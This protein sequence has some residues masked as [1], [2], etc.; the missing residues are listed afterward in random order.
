[1]V[2]GKAVPMRILVVVMSLFLPSLAN[3]SLDVA[4][5]DA[6]ITVESSRYAVTVDRRSG[7]ITRLGQR[8][9]QQVDR[10]DDYGF[11]KDGRSKITIEKTD[12]GR[13]TV[14]I[15]GAFVRKGRKTPSDL[16][17]V[18]RYVFHDRSSV[19]GCFVTVRQHNIQTHSDVYMTPSW[20][21]L[22]LLDFSDVAAERKAFSRQIAAKRFFF[23][24]GAADL[25]QLFAV[26]DK[27]RAKFAELTRPKIPIARTLLDDPLTDKTN[28]IDISGAW[29]ANRGKMTERSPATNNAFTVAAVPPVRDCLLETS[30][31]NNDGSDHVYLCGR[32]Q[33]ARNH[34]SMSYLNFPAHAVRIDRVVNGRRTVL[35]EVNGVPD[36]RVKPDTH[37]AFE[38]RGSRLRAFRNNELLVEAVDST[39][40]S[41]RV[42]LGV[43]GEYPTTFS[44]VR[45][46]EVQPLQSAIAAIRIEQPPTRHAYFR[47]ETNA[48]SPLLITSN[49]DVE[50]P[51]VVIAIENQTHLRD[52]PVHEQRIELGSLKAGE[53]R[54][55]ECPL[56][57]ALWRSGDYTVSAVVTSPTRK[58]GTESNIAP[59]LA[60]RASDQRVLARARF[61]IYLRKRPN[62]ERMIV[63]AW[64][65]G[66][67]KLLAEHGF[68]RFKVH[69]A[70]TIS[71]WRDGKHYVIDNP[72]RLQ[73]ATAAPRLQYLHD[74]FDECVRYG[75]QGYL[76]LEYTR[77]LAEGVEAAYALK[78]NGTELQTRA[79]DF[80]ELG[81][82]R[83]NPFHPDNIAT[84]TNFW[85]T[86]LQAF[87]DMPGWQ[88]TLLNSESERTLDVYGNDYWL[89][90]ARKEL[91][92]DVPRD[93]ADPWG[94]KPKDRPLPADGIVETNDPYYRFYRWWW[95]RGEGQGMLHAK[96]AEVV[97][98]I[99]PDMRVWHDPALRQPFVRG[100]LRGLD[101]IWQW[102][103][104]WPM[105][106]R[107]PLVADE[108]KLAAVDNQVTVLQL[109]LIAWG[110][111][112][113]PRDAPRWPYVKRDFYLA[114]HSPAVMRQ[115]VWLALSRG[116]G[117]IS[118]H[119]LE[120]VH[121]T[122]LKPGDDLRE[123]RGIGHRAYMY[124]SPDTLAA[125]S[126]MNRRVLAPYGMVTKQM[127]PP[128]AQVAMLLSTANAV[129]AYRD[130]M[131]F[132]AQEA[133][134]MYAKLQA[135]HIPVDVVYESDI[136]QRG[137]AGYEAIA[138]PGCR[139]LPRHIYN[140]VA[141]FAR[142]GGI[143]IADQHLVAE[144]PNVFKLPQKNSS[145]QPGEKLQEERTS[146]A[147]RIRELLDGKIDRWADCDS[148]SVALSTLSDGTNRWLF[149]TNLLMQP[150]EYLGGFGKVLDD[151]I[152]QHIQLSIAQTECVIYD[153]LHQRQIKPTTEDGRLTWQV[154]LAPGDGQMFAILPAPI[155]DVGVGVPDSV[156]RGM[157]CKATIHVRGQ[158]GE[159]MRGLIPLRITIRDS[160][161]T[162]HDFSDY[163]YARDGNATF[164]WP[165][166]INEPSGDWTIQV[167]ELFS[168][169]VGRTFFRV[170]GHEQS[171]QP[172]TRAHS[173]KKE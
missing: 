19:V 38:L 48:A 25:A 98:E 9:V 118:Y 108:M 76:Q 71:R 81:Q 60:R 150:G 30:V 125:I 79:N 36:L 124:S 113:I 160:Q 152:P 12:P 34:Y 106:A 104:A 24:P 134:S 66:D 117:G 90:M 45:V 120:S 29:S 102:V 155:Q 47:D 97:R 35:A 84:I 145:W 128:K 5:S 111:V 154:A 129:L 32:W 44:K 95:E 7:T 138:L 57:P 2:Y 144:L 56:K 139:V 119:G 94:M 165:I 123:V 107:I 122:G 15:K 163:S 18:Y 3:A 43:A 105:P 69:H 16:T 143:V 17:A 54:R 167:Q 39:F 130:A 173:P 63:G 67:A 82:P 159:L 161:G 172:G 151:G 169:T 158:D 51:S 101:E 131:D 153:V 11:G 156:A 77:R 4:E 110:D 70:G 68:N 80:Y 53:P 121:K 22:C 135:A 14:T 170:A 55:I 26:S 92:F 59:S 146:E 72:K 116:I 103:Y 136:E 148:T 49:R 37:L 137:L 91:G 115:S 42:A 10:A 75:L 61:T 33:D 28:W 31:W 141:K 133:G 147:A 112:A 20:K 164:S 96:V 41:G 142:E 58:R 52:G 73:T 93:A 64:D 86:D 140:A 40:A 23:K 99:R 1:M 85:R 114:A 89:R 126:E 46:H 6:T 13:I 87:K 8:D 74:R 100:R 27:E 88:A 162:V 132:R 168:G 127:K 171:D 109:Q 83:P 157:K 21:Q 78:R 65:S 166:A 62:L 149:A 50:G